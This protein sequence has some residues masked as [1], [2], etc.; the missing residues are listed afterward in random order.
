MLLAVLAVVDDH[1]VGAEDVDQQPDLAERVARAQHPRQLVGR[2]AAA[3][4][5][6]AAERAEVDWVLGL[7][8]APARTRVGGDARES[9][10]WEW[11]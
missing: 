2:R 9:R 10:R 5:G 7:A 6:A 8:P 11:Q 1:R 3:A 4:G